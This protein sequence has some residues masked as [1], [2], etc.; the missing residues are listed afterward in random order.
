MPPNPVPGAVK[1]SIVLDVL[2]KHN[3]FVAAKSNEFTLNKGDIV[4]VYRFPDPLH[5]RMIHRLSRKFD[6]PIHHFYHQELIDQ[7]LLS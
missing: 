7:T 5:R 3:V 6:I 4:E 2:K 1:R